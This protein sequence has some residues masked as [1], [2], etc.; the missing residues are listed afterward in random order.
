MVDPRPRA[1]VSPAQEFYENYL[2]DRPRNIAIGAI[3]LTL[4][5]AVFVLALDA[6]SNRHLKTVI[7]SAVR[8]HES[9]T[10]HVWSV[11]SKLAYS[12]T[13]ASQVSD[14]AWAIVGGLDVLRSTELSDLQQRVVVRAGDFCVQVGARIADLSGHSPE[15]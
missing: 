6:I 14:P 12:S 3:C 7:I 15:R 13:I 2:T 4:V 1:Q 5:V 8:Q 11:M 9:K 10:E